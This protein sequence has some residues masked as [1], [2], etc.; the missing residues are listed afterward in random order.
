MVQMRALTCLWVEIDDRECVDVVLFHA[1]EKR[2]K[3]K[4]VRIK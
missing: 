4:K 3:K 1:R 2:K